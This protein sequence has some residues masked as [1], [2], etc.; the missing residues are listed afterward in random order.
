M[1]GRAIKG[2]DSVREFCGIEIVKTGDIR[3]GNV[4]TPILS[5]DGPIERGCLTDRE[6]K[7]KSRYQKATTNG[8]ER[9]RTKRRRE[10]PQM[11]ADRRR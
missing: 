6:T 2:G 7:N 11:N 10:E 1:D 5:D 8:R 9:T 3:Q 4:V